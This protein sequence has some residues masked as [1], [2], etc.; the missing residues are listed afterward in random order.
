MSEVA[1]V[2]GVG[3]WVLS[4]GAACADR[5]G[6]GSP[7]QDSCLP[8]RP[9]HLSPALRPTSAVLA[10]LI[11]AGFWGDSA[12]A[13]T[14]PPLG[15]LGCRQ[16]QAE[17]PW[18]EKTVLR[19]ME[20]VVCACVPTT[21]HQGLWEGEQGTRPVVW[22]PSTGLRVCPSGRAVLLGDRIRRLRRGSSCVSW[23][24]RG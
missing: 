23:A 11:S 9:C 16:A 6:L 7:S 18:R 10:R 13:P 21:G 2:P 12:Q 20:Q 1:H 17:A 22:T 24:C 8:G 15:A 19:C 3:W 14:W 4:C 5:C